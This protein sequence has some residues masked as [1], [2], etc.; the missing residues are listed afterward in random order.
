MRFQLMDAILAERIFPFLTDS[1]E[2]VIC[3]FCEVPKGKTAQT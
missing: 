3:S 2:E 1:H